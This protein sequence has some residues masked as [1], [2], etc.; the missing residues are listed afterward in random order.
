MRK[1]SPD[2]PYLAIDKNLL[3]KNIERMARKTS[4]AGINLRPH[5][6][7]HKIPELAKLQIASGAV[8]ITVATIGEAEVF[9]KKGIRDIFIA[10][11]LYVTESKLKRLVKLSRKVK[12]TLAVDSTQGAKALA[13][14]VAGVK[15]LVEIDSGHH[16]SGCDPKQAGEVAREAKALGLNPVGIFT[17]P[18]HSY[19]PKGAR[20]AVAD[21]QRALKEA[22]TA[23][24]KM[25]IEA[26][27][28]SSGST[29]SA[30]VSAESSGTSRKSKSLVNELR[31]GVYVFNDAQQLE[32]G[33]CTSNQI[34]LWAVATVVS[35]SGNRMILD[36]GSKTLGADR[37]GWATGYGRLL[38]FPDARIEALS[39]HHA[40]VVFPKTKKPKAGAKASGRK[41]PKIGDVLRVAPNHVCNAVNLVD[42][43]YLVENQE[44]VGSWKVAARGRNS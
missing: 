43:V 10:Y 21:E 16:R 32:L 11:P 40:T 36:S 6:K 35:V 4:K 15:I 23:M 22:A 8:G 24:S 5:V 13:M 12:L 37:A 7:T 25:G 28:I 26:K 9:A 33:T 31:P 30:S 27:I 44:V 39:E 42:R 38:D 17:F 20:Q 18:G 19:K 34:A 3:A 41:L 2:T 1:L 29:P 14:A